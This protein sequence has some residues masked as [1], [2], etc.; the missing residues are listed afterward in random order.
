[1]KTPII[2]YGGK[3]SIIQHIQEMVPVHSAYAEWFCG[4]ATLLFQKDP[5]RHELINDR[6]DIV[7][8]FYQQLKYNFKKL[9]R[10]IDAS[11]YSRSLLKRANHIFMSHKVGLPVDKI[12][13]AWAFWYSCHVSYSQKLFSS[14]LKYSMSNDVK[15]D[16]LQQKKREFTEQLSRRIEHV[17]IEHRDFRQI[18]KTRNKPEFFHYQDPPYIDA[19]MGHYK[20]SFTRDDFEELLEWNATQMNG[21]FLLSSYHNDIL[22]EYIAKYGWFCREISLGVGGGKTTRTSKVELLVSNYNTA[23]GTLKLF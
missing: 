5:V 23:C 7:V 2:Y 18:A 17:I 21:K 20:G 13:L 8:N 3:T 14:G 4:G 1:M 9:H 12:D 16:I 22:S 11:V 6:L 10:H 15:P 19:D